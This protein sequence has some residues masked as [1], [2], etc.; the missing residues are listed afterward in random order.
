M[1][2]HH[3]LDNMS[4]LSEKNTCV[5]HGI[6]C[7]LRIVFERDGTYHER[8][9][10]FR[11]RLSRQILNELLFALVVIHHALNH[12]SALSKN[13]LRTSWNIMSVTIDALVDTARDTLF[14]SLIY[15]PE[16]VIHSTAIFR[17]QP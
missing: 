11:D 15:C 7:L 12:I 3:A 2:K 17:Y 5:R 16:R 9:L 14:D 6:F 10:A 8:E 13:V 4:A 1:I